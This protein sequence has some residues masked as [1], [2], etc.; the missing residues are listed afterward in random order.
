VSVFTCCE[1]S[2]RALSK[3]AAKSAS[4]R[5]RSMGLLPAKTDWVMRATICETCPLRVVSRGASY[6]GRPFLQKI[7]RDPVLDGCGCPTRAKAQDPTEH[8]PITPRFLK[9]SETP[10]DCNC[11]WCEAARRG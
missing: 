10:T 8:C 6:C 3:A 7:D 9:S 11:K 2:L 1:N 5:M 4:S